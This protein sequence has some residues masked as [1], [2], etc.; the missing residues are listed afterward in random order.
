MLS[1][2]LL[3]VITA[4]LSRMYHKQVH[5]LADGW[6][7]QGERDMQAGN[8]PGALTDYRN[9]LVYNPSNTRF[10]FSLATA[11]AAAG[12]GNE[13]RAYLLNLLSES[14]GR[15]EVNLEL[16][17][18]AAQN[19]QT[20]DAVRY[21]QG[22][23][24][25]EWD[26][27]PIA[28]RWQIRKELCEFLLD[29][30]FVKQAT[31]EVIALEEN[32][33]PNDVQ[34]L[35]IVG[36]LLLRTQQWTR[37]QELYRDLLSTDRYDEEALAGAAKTAFELGQYSDAL[38][39]FNRLPREAVT[40][41]ISQALTTCRGACSAVDPF[42]A[43]LSAKNKALRATDALTLAQTRLQNCARQNGESL[44][45]TPPRTDLQILWAQFQRT[46][47][48]WTQRDLERF[49]E[50]LDASMEFVFGVENAAQILR[51]APRRRSRALAARAQHFRGEPLSEIP[52]PALVTARPPEDATTVG[53]PFPAR[54]SFPL[55]GKP[56]PQRFS[57][58]G[59]IGYSSCLRCSLESFRG[60][61]LSVSAWRLIL[62]ANYAAGTVVVPIISASRPCA[63]TR[64]SCCGRAGDPRVSGRSWQRS[65]SHQEQQ[66]TFRM[67]TCR[68]VTVIGKFVTSAIAIG[69][70]Q[71]W[72]PK[73]LRC[74]WAPA[75]L[76]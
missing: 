12:R 31:P 8:V 45:E 71:T 4:F 5:Q 18:V 25:G 56:G 47:S 30:G 41:R 19:N 10:Q 16:A 24:Y 69:S 27:D 36:Q 38:Q 42:V 17:R 53:S 21:Y 34:R 23:I 52:T 35:K 75:S 44:L 55:A 33:P 7:A 76:H 66:F 73:T 15:G 58:C 65:E 63:G 14:P 50:R 1:L 11:L 2:L 57:L 22:A 46:Q 74:R 20:A 62:D 68:L 29:H 32:T 26:A 39:Y 64:R 3:V 28:T 60:L 51:R 54:S 9:A 43:G 40:P 6:F 13:A 61:P 70:G 72:V 37:A 59:R 48:D 49:P 67:A